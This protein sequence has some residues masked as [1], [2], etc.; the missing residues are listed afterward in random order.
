MP[1]SS[2][3]SRLREELAI[4]NTPCGSLLASTVMLAVELCVSITAAPGDDIPVVI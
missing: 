4:L 2:V 3:S 1:I